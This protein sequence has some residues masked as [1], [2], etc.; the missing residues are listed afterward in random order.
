MDDYCAMSQN[1]LWLPFLNGKT[2]FFK[3]YFKNV[4]AFIF[5]NF[6]R[7]FIENFLWEF[8]F[9]NFG[10]VTI[11]RAKRKFV[12]WQPFLKRNIFFWFFGADKWLFVGVFTCGASFV[13]K[14]LRKSTPKWL[15]PS[16]L[17][18]TSLLN[19]PKAHNWM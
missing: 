17:V 3:L 7:N 13:P 18:L 19:I 2:F 5:F 11:S 1:L 16:G 4:N 6:E 10:H 15:G 12:S 9:S 14:F 8:F